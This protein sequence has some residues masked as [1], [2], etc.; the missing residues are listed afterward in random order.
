[1]EKQSKRRFFVLL[2]LTLIIV[3][4]L[5]IAMGAVKISPLVVLKS[6]LGRESGTQYNIIRHIRLPRSVAALSVGAFLSCAGLVLQTVLNNA[7]AGPSVIG[8]NAGA[9]FFALAAMIFVPGSFYTV[10]ISAFI[11]ALAAVLLVYEI[12]RKTGASRLTIVLS[13][14]AVSSLFNA[15]SDTLLTFYPGSAANKVSF[16]IGGLSAVS[17]GTL[18]WSVALGAIALTAAFFMSS[19][20]NVMLLGDDMAQSLGL[21]VKLTRFFALVVSAALV[22]AAIAVCGQIS[23]V[24]LICPHIGRRLW[25]SDVKTLMPRVTM[26]GSVLVLVC[27]TLSRVLFAP[28]EIPVGILLSFLGAP[29]FIYLLLSKKRGK[30]NDNG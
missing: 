8:V 23:F 25:D 4:I 10:P 1:M 2:P 14:V 15:L 24:G 26:L 19:G 17:V 5:S 12:G 13:G 9:S 22:G 6:I 28:F 3:F 11:G 27:D 18:K 29:F 21:N 7:I 20:L 30:P 16:S